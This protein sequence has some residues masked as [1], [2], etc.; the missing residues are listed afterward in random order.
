MDGKE[1][2][3]LCLKDLGKLPYLQAVLKETLRK[4]SIA[5]LAIVHQTVEESW[6]ERVCA[7]MDLANFHVPITLAS[8]LLKFEWACVKEGSPPDLTRHIPSLLVSMKYPLEA[9]ITC[10]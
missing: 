2:G 8:L 5:P 9:R 4:E 6:K 3:L 7:G 10:R 1:G